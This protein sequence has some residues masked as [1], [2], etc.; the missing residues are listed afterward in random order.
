MV[1]GIGSKVGEAMCT[2][3]HTNLISFTGSTLIG[4][5]IASLAAPA[6]KKLSLELGGK[7]AAIVF[8]DV[9]LDE[10]LPGLIRSCFANQGEICLCTSRLYVQSKIYD[11]FLEKFVDGASKV[12]INFKKRKINFF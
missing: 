11:Q 2:H 7:N 3:H 10:I 8:A 1:L 12:E 4:R 6:H 5:R 9:D